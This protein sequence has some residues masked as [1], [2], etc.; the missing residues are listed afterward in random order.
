MANFKV[1]ANGPDIGEYDLPLG[2]NMKLLQWGGDP[3]GNRLALAL[4]P[5]GRGAELTVLPDNVSAAST[6]FAL[7]SNS[8]GTS[9]RVTASQQG[10]GRT[11]GFSEALQVTVCGAPKKQPGYEVDLLADLAAHGS[12]YQAYAYA[13]I[14]KDKGNF[15]HFLS[16]NTTPGHYNCGD[17][18]ASYGRKVFGKETFT[19]SIAYYLPAKTDQI[20]DLRFNPTLVEH[21]I[22]KIQ[23]HLRRG[24]P[25]RVWLIHHDGFSHPVIHGDPRTHYLTIVGFSSNKFLYLDPWPGGSILKYSGGMYSDREIAFMGE[26][27]FDR[28]HRDLGIFSPLGR[29]GRHN[30]TVIAGP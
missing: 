25:V 17:V 19:A 4:D 30:Y 28:T 11:P 20:A 14:M 23:L 7:K 27:T 6:L 13:R 26:L 8:Q 3:R 15:G 21:G 24:T 1:S 18:A 29:L 2:R 16:Q 12:S 9:F 5:P 22:Q 10:D